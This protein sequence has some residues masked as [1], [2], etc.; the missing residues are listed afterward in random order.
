MNIESK[1]FI[2]FSNF[3]NSVELDGLR[4]RRINSL[5][6]FPKVCQLFENVFHQP[7]VP[8]YWQWKYLQGPGANSFGIVVEH[9]ETGCMVGHMGVQV[10]PGM[11]AGEALRM[12]QVCDVMLHPEYR[13]GIGPHS[14]YL[15]MNYALRQLAHGPC[16]K[17]P[18]YMYGFPGVRPANLG[19]RIGVYR[20]LLVCNEYKTLSGQ[21][22]GYS[23]KNF[24][25]HLNPWR[26]HIEQIQEEDFLQ[27]DSVFDEIWQR[28]SEINSLV[29]KIIKNAAYIRWRYWMHPH[30][31]LDSAQSLYAL[32]GLRKG[33]ELVGWLVT[34]MQSQPTVVDSCLPS[35]QI[36]EA[37][38]LLPMPSPESQ[39]GWISWL[40]QSKVPAVSTPIHAVE[41]LGQP[42]HVD[43]PCPDFQPGD[44]DVY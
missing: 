37:L 38:R 42:F 31:N 18:L 29:P 7:M 12:G 9:M 16:T 34:R 17:P 19:E 27:M 39:K 28:Y 40:A 43:W 14:T 44:T 6:D 20:R 25:H 23:I 2:D 33:R 32:W 36:T 41:V 24:L 15:R 21:T 8:S 26:L 11:R 5:I 4:Y 3:N 1:F 30:Q 13:A 10:L 35:D 22:D